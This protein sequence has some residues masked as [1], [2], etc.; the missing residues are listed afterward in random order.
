MQ[1]DD[2]ARAIAARLTKA[3]RESHEALLEACCGD[4]KCWAENDLDGWMPMGCWKC[5]EKAARVRAALAE[6][7]AGR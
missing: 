4:P 5:E 1:S 3:Q 2:E 6:M 7:E